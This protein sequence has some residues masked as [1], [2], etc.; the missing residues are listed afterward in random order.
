MI[1]YQIK[2]FSNL[3]KSQVDQ[4]TKFTISP[5]SKYVYE[6]KKKPKQNKYW[7]DKCLRRSLIMQIIK[8]LF[9]CIL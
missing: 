7:Q 4:N 2:T 3:Q 8:I 6:A 5:I 1:I 9:S